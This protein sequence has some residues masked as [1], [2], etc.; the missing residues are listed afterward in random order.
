MI[1]NGFYRHRRTDPSRSWAGR[2][3]AGVARWPGR[4]RPGETATRLLDVG[5]G[6][7]RG[8]LALQER[9]QQ[10]TALDVSAGAVAVCRRR[11]VR[12]VYHGTIRQ[13]AAD[14][15]AGVFDS[16]LLLGNNIGLLGSRENAV[17]FLAALGRLIKPGG[18]VA[19]LIVDPYETAQPVHL[20]Y[21][22][23]NRQLGRLPG[24]LTIRVRYQ[25]LATPW[26]DWL[27]ASPDELTALAEAA[28]WKAST[29]YGGS[30]YVAILASRPTS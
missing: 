9:G 1:M 12:D 10:V 18:V 22:E 3:L 15:L 24:Q 25:N 20:A 27:C 21:H 28:R 23:R 26:F 8:A 14:G 30:S 6:A 4:T 2:W 5:A 11:G 17:P 13:A 19:G 16:A 7:G 29:A